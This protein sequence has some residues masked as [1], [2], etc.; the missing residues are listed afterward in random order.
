MIRPVGRSLP[1]GDTSTHAS[2]ATIAF[3][4]AMSV[5]TTACGAG[6]AA[7]PQGGG[8]RPAESTPRSTAALTLPRTFALEFVDAVVIP[9]GAV[10]AE[11]GDRP[12]GGL[13][14]LTPGPRPHEYWAISD[15]A[16]APRLMRFRV[17]VEQ[18]RLTVTP[19][20]FE[21]IALPAAD[22]SDGAATDFEGLTCS[23]DETCYLSSEGNQEREPRVPPSILARR[24][25]RTV[26]RLTLPDKVRPP[27]AGPATQGVRPNE[28]FEALALT[29]DGSRLIAAAESAL[30]QD[31]DRPTSDR[32]ALVRMVTFDRVE[33][34][35]APSAE[36]A[37]PVDAVDI[38]ADYEQPSGAIG[39]VEILPLA[40]GTVLSMERAF[41]REGAGAK[42]SLNHITIFRA[43]FE[44]ATDLRAHFSLRGAPDVRPMRKSRILSLGDLAP[45]LPSTLATLDNFEGLSVGPRLPN[46]DSTLLLLS[47][48]N[49]SKS[50]VTAFLLLRVAPAP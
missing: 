20:G 8:A 13:S 7:P 38:P 19:L 34:G 16:T 27:V 31:G 12:V 10:F 5:L 9:S 18:G 36:Y 14:A 47:D 1:S 49:F 21:T 3:V 39:L 17:A 50:Q 25:G 46:G 4:L 11:M 48:D 26:E 24:A 45:R 44:G 37:Y 43:S 35:F 32:G 30:V 22:T 29:P 28:A 23:T 33:R 42:R 40:D 41:V 6:R 2:S 15:E